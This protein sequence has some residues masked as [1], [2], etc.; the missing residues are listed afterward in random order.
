MSS[1]FGKFMRHRQ[2]PLLK[3]DVKRTRR[4]LEKKKNAQGHRKVYGVVIARQGKQKKRQKQQLREKQY[5]RHVVRSTIETMD[6][7]ITAV[8]C[9]CYKLFLGSHLTQ[10]LSLKSQY[11]K[12]QELLKIVSYKYFHAVTLRPSP[13]DSCVEA[14]VLNGAS[15]NNDKT[16]KLSYHFKETFLR[17]LHTWCQSGTLKTLSEQSYNLKLQHVPFL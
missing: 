7:Q 14:K 10:I 13:V 3:L 17:I 11:A 2:Y 4:P 6:E 16:S 15:A 8:R 1:R 9:C 12:L 5:E